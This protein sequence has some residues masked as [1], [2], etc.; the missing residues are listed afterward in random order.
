MAWERAFNCRC[1]P[2]F[3]NQRIVVSQF[4]AAFNIHQ[5]ININATILMFE[6]LAIRFAGMIDEA[7]L[8]A[9]PG[10]ID[11]AAVSQA[12]EK[13]MADG[14]ARRFGARKRGC[15]FNPL[16]LVLDDAFAGRNSAARKNAVA[17]DTGG[18]NYVWRQFSHEL[19]QSRRL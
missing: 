2:S 12:E 15:P 4:F 1:M 7:C 16:A 18:F 8:V 5:R 6:R 11:H 14:G 9:M 3:V 13:G 19:F 10:A 17:M